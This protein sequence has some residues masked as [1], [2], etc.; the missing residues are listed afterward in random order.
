[1][2]TPPEHTAGKADVLAAV[3]RMGALQSR[4]H[5]CDRTQPAYMVLWERLGQYDPR[6]LDELLAE[7]R[8]LNTG[9]TPRVSC[10]LRITRFTAYHAGSPV[11]ARWEEWYAERQAEINAVLEHVRAKRGRYA[12]LILNART[13]RKGNLVGLEVEKSAG[14]WHTWVS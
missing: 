8:C 10:P 11:G 5:Q 14:I 9:H 4:H 12:R 1:M 6:W 7:G 13:A 3:R 2:L